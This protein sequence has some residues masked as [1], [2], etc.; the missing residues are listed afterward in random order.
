M[1]P[2]NRSL[3][4]IGVAVAAILAA[5]AIW[6]VSSPKQPE[7]GPELDKNI[8]LAALG[9][10]I[11]AECRLEGIPD[12]YRSCVAEFSKDGSGWRVKVTYDGLYDDSVR[13]SRVEGYLYYEG[14]QWFASGVAETQRCHEGRGHQDFSKELC[15]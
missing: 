2:R 4:Y 1:S 14:G 5:L 15:A 10:A 12:T 11:F 3:I 6:A 13:A 9:P 7:M 8:A